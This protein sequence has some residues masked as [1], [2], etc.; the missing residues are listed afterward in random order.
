MAKKSTDIQIS[1]PV[2]VAQAPAHI[3]DWGPW[4]FPYIERL[5]DGR[6]HIQYWVGADHASDYGSEKS[7]HAVSSDN[8]I[9]WYKDDDVFFQG[10]LL[11]NGDRLS[12]VHKPSIPVD[13]L[14][15]P[16]PVGSKPASYAGHLD[17]AYHY[18]DCSEMNKEL[19]DFWMQ[20]RYIPE[21]GYR[22][23]EKASVDIPDHAIY[24][25]D[26]LLVFPVMWCGIHVA[27]DGTLYTPMYTINRIKNNEVS[28]S[29]YITILI[30]NDNGYNWRLL[31]EIE[32][33]P[34]KQVDSLWDKRDGFSEPFLS[35]MPDGSMLCLIR[36]SDGNGIGPLYCSKS[37]DK[38]KTW[39]RPE[40]FDDL[41]VLP[42]LLVLKNGITLAS[43]GRPGFYIRATSDPSGEIWDNR[44]QIL[45]PA[46]NSVANTCAYSDM[47]ALDDSTALVVYSDFDYPDKNGEKCK[48]ILARKITTKMI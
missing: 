46:D 2:V 43:Y 20:Q 25:V 33:Q 18:Y 13:K 6:L 42:K 5:Y 7:G 32:Y 38:G 24:S 45:K 12:P 28:K 15:L 39:S 17:P 4:Q 40:V 44:I 36:T 14:D 31:S 22:A 34:N 23:T 8:G 26:K 1:P 47:I 21:K 11:A 19:M 3:K 48:T 9:T 30:S 10:V 41:G 35:F 29:W 37:N 27:D 16:V